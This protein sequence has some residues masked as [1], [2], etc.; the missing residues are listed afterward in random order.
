[1]NSYRVDINMSTL[2]A[3][4]DVV[5]LKEHRKGGGMEGVLSYH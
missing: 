1:M 2:Y 3:F 4:D 5:G